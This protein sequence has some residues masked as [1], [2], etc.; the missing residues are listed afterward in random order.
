MNKRQYIDVHQHLAA[1][2]KGTNSLFTLDQIIKK[3][4]SVNY[5]FFT[6]PL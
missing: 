3:I 4:T 2:I 5:T 6:V 1:Q